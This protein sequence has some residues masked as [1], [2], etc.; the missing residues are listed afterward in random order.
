MYHQLLVVIKWKSPDSQ[1]NFTLCS[2]KSWWS[3]RDTPGSARGHEQIL[4][5]EQPSPSAPSPEQ[6]DFMP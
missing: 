4:N 1:L 6:T 2:T 3:R 5:L